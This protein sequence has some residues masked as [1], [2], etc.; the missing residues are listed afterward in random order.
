[1]SNQIFNNLATLEN[2]SAITGNNAI[3]IFIF[4]L[5]I[6]LSMLL[7]G[8]QDSPQLP[9]NINLPPNIQSIKPVINIDADSD[10]TPVASI[11]GHKFYDVDIDV[12]IS[13]LPKNLQHVR[14]DD[15]AR[16]HILR[17]IVHR[18]LLS[19]RARA[20][21]LD[22]QAHVQTAMQRAYDQI[23]IDDLEHWRMQQFT[24]PAKKTVANYYNEY[25]QDF[26]NPE[27]IHARHIL[28][29]NKEIADN[30]YKRLLNGAD[31]TALA[32]MNSLDDSNKSRGGD[33]N[34]FARGIMVAEFENAAFAL[35]KEK[36]LSE[37]VQ[38]HFG[39]HLIQFLDRKTASVKTLD[40]SREE[41]IERL[42]T[43]AWQSWLVELEN[44]ADLLII[45]P[46]YNWHYNQEYKQ[47][48]V[49]LDNDIYSKHN[50][51]KEQ[52]KKDS[53]KP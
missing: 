23:I 2:T 13:Q 53:T 26:T 50:D 16:S 37:P 17:A 27:Q 32:A 21:D 29:A 51:N 6:F 14:H 22:K 19:Q 9:E 43:Q 33:L 34:W 15:A 49:Q 12:E 35:N 39:W 8:C 20:L 52:N 48:K 18:Y 41:I 4:I 42:R 36:T 46:A 25:L 7:V 44:A 3:I 38:T 30:I 45:E 31:F 1:M 28:V 5:L 24:E 11:A 40:E 47:K 10:I